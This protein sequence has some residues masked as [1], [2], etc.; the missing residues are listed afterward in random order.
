MAVVRDPEDRFGFG[1]NWADFIE[2]NFTEE[3][4]EIARKHLLEVLK[5]DDLKGKTFLDIGCGSG[6]HSLGAF[7]SGAEKVISF[8]YDVNSV[9]TTKKLR[10]FAGK[11][12]NWDVMQGSVLDGE[13]IKTL[14]EVD[15]VYSWG[16]LHHTGAMWDA[17]TNAA[18]PVKHGGVFYIAL[19]TTDVYINPPPEKWLE[20]KQEYNKAGSLR[21]RVMEFSYAY[22]RVIKPELKKLRNPLKVM[23]EYKASRGMSF[24]TDVRDWLG[25]WPMEFAGI[26]E[27]KDFAKDKLGMELVNIIAGEGNTEYVFRHVGAHNYWDE[28][29]QGLRFEVLKAPYSNVDRNSWGCEIA[30]EQSTADTAENPRASELMLYEDGVPVGFGHIAENQIAAHGG[31]RYRHAAKS[32]TFSSTDNSDPNTNGRE[33]KYSVP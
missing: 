30:N 26:Q 5:L 28:Y 22:P 21:K 24:W 27:T 32:L 33:Y 29:F 23:K 16:V 18:I 10:D 15:I 19:Y 20:I 8:D 2:H 17:I 9:S 4:I 12:D 31:G 11:P 3:R 1:Q 14:P 13:L 25:G 6:L 7:R